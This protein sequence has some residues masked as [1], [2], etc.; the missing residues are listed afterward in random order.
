VIGGSVGSFTWHQVLQV[1]LLLLLAL[2]AQTNGRA[3]EQDGR[4]ETGSDSC[5]G[6]DVRPV[7]GNLRVVAQDLQI[8]SNI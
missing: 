5:P 2:V 1:Q 4:Q 6:H 8:Q 3:G 7:V